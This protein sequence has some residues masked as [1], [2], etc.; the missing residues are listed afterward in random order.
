MAFGGI[1]K[2]RS[3]DMKMAA[4]YAEA[5]DDTRDESDEGEVEG[6]E[7]TEEYMYYSEQEDRKRKHVKSHGT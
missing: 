6:D 3:L 4:E 1:S 2:G 7:N 5:M